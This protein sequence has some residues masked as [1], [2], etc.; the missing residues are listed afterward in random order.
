M[1][2]ARNTTQIFYLE[3]INQLSLLL[4]SREGKKTFYRALPEDVTTQEEMNLDSILSK[5]L[6]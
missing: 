5:M 3:S 4:E 2:S 1:T 6:L